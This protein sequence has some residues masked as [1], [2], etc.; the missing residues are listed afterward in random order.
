LWKK[1]G[2]LL[3]GI[4]VRGSSIYINNSRSWKSSVVASRDTIGRSAIDL[5]FRAGD[6]SFVGM[7]DH[8]SRVGG[9]GEAGQP[10]G[11]KG[12]VSPIDG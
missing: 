3:H 10:S 6:V 5:P 2:K 11:A 1:K 9:G 8:Q 12:A 7:T 4:L